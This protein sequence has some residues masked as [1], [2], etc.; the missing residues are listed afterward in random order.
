MLT[1]ID[2]LMIGGYFALL[3]GVV[4][5]TMMRKKIQSGEDLFLVGRSVG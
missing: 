4:V 3:A 5:F 1:W 2:W